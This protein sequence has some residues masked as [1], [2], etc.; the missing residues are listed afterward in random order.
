VYD[1]EQDEQM[2]FSAINKVARQEVRSVDY[3]HWWTFL[4]Y[5]NEVGEGTFSYIARLRNKL[6]HGKKL[7]KD[8][9]EFVNK[10]KDMVVLK[11]KLTAEEQEEEDAF[12]A[13]LDD[14]IG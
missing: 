4:G 1:W 9:R 6:N 12:Q 13:L 5:F 8:E 7:D 3:M 10:H 2:I 11:K 14:V